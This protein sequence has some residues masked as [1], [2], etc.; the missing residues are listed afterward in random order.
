MMSTVEAVTAAECLHRNNNKKAIFSA[1]FLKKTRP[2]VRPAVKLS[3]PDIYQLPA[4][5]G[6]LRN[7]C[8][9]SGSG[10]WLYV[11]WL[12]EFWQREQQGEGRR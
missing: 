9:V 8:S 11:L 6:S 3:N 10:W 5:P 12:K 7:T 2:A 4:K 1:P